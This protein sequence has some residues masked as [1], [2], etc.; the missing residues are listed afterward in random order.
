MKLWRFFYVSF[1]I[2]LAMGAQENAAGRAA[3]PSASDGSV[4]NLPIKADITT[5]YAGKHPLF[6]VKCDAAGNIYLTLYK[7]DEAVN[8]TLLLQPLQKI[9]PD[10]M[11]GESF[12]IKDALP[13]LGAH[14]G[15]F[16][17]TVHGDGSV[18]AIAW[19]GKGLQLVDFAK[20][21]SVLSK[22]KVEKA[23]F[24]PSHFAIFPSGSALV[25]GIGGEM[26]HTPFLAVIDSK[27]RIVTELKPENDK[28]FQAQAE[29]GDVQ[30]LSTGT[31]GSGN[32]AV[33]SGE[34][35]AAS[36]GNIYVLRRANPAVVYAVSPGGQVLRTFSVDPGDPG[37]MPMGMKAAQ[38]QL[39]IAFD[40]DGKRDLM[41]KTVDFEGH[42]LASYSVADG[43]FMG[44]FACYAPPN[45]VFTK[46]KGDFVEFLTVGPDNALTA[47]GRP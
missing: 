13:E 24:N 44:F 8:G 45:F 37:L 11:L 16:A 7:F 17:F 3:A 28:R 33:S 38:G 18:T 2:A 41:I 40:R 34:S 10:G 32:T 42:G 9:K 30:F 26:E 39:A 36:D 25:S 14:E 22:T 5:E 23:R 6:P 47:G 43:R 12:K 21:G 15:M 31:P 29:A 27:G 35:V 20:D 19:S 4:L 46:S 1:F